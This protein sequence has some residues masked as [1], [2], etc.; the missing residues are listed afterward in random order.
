MKMV[1]QEPQ[2]NSLLHK[3]N[4]GIGK[5]KIRINFSILQIRQRLAEN[6][7]AFIQEKQ[8]TLCKQFYSI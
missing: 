3:S 1:E 4:K 2:K 5:K 8:L 6:Q 7:G